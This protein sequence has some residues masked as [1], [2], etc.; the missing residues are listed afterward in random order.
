MLVRYE[1]LDRTVAQLQRRAL[2]G[3]AADGVTAG[4]I[5]LLPY[6]RRGL[7]ELP[8]ME[9]AFVE[10]DGFSARPVKPTPVPATQDAP[11]ESSAIE[12]D[13]LR[14]ETAPDGTLTLIDK[15][16]GRR[17]EQLHRL[18]DEADVGDLYNFCPIE[19][20]APWRSESATTLVLREGALVH[21][22][23]LRFAGDDAVTTV[24]RLVD[25]IRRVEFRTTID[26]RT[27]DHRLRAVFPVPEASDVRA[28]G[29][30]ALV[31]RPLVPPAP[32]T[33]GPSRPTRRTTRSGRSRSVAR[34]PHQ[35]TPRIR[36]APSRNRR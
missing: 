14:V 10:L 32:R 5:N 36:S 1:Q 13:C 27:E 3:F 30:F 33:D 20:A 29:Q 4:A 9:P 34:A 17:Y 6:R 23:E 26:N 24:V 15:Q 21:E 18:E 16:T 7:V 28:E 11:A 8:G 31:H 19:G 25:G 12:S 22:L 2:D 35:G